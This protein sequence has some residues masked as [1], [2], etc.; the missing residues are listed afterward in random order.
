VDAA[1]A[2]KAQKE[3]GEVTSDHTFKPKLR[4]ELCCRFFGRG[5]E[6]QNHPKMIPKNVVYL[7]D[8]FEMFFV[9]GRFFL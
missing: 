4:S 2:Q 7:L 5:M 1:N 8:W 6:K 3:M 9:P